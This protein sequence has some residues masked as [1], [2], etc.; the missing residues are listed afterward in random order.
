MKN[1]II[2]L[3]LLVTSCSKPA[4]QIQYIKGYWEIKHVKL[5][6]GLERDYGFNETIDYFIITDSLSGYRKKL[7]PN[8]NGTFETSKD[9]E[10]IKIRIENNSLNIYYHTPFSNWKETVLL[11]TKEQLKIINENMDVFLYQRYIPLNS[12]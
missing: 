11:A 10:N 7:K 12:K 5:S 4:K 3:L 9:I 6:N 1:H 8:F 2:I